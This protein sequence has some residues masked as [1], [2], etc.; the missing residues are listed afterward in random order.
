MQVEEK[1]EWVESTIAFYR[2]LRDG[3]ICVFVAGQPGVDTEKRP[4]SAVVRTQKYYA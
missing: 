1:D 2:V 3:E 4:A